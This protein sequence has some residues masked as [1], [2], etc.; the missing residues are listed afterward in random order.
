M[1]AIDPYFFGPIYWRIINQVCLQLDQM[2]NTYRTRYLFDL[3]QI[4]IYSVALCLPCIYC[5]ESLRMLLSQDPVYNATT[6]MTW[7]LF[8]TLHRSYKDCVFRRYS[9]E[10]RMAVNTKLM[11]SCPAVMDSIVS[12]DHALEHVFVVCETPTLRV[13]L[14]VLKTRLGNTY[15]PRLIEYIRIIFELA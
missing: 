14:D 4:F 3:F 13:D 7:E 5:K 15:T 6:S 10:L 1:S 9:Y 12:W 8:E 11:W 2:M